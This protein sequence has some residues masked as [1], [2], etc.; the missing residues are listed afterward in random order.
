LS[1]KL[2]EKKR[3]EDAAREA[4]AR[5]GQ[6]GS[7]D[8]SEKIRTYNFPQD[9][10]TDHR[11]GHTVHNLARLMTGDIEPFLS[12]VRTKLQAEQLAAD[13]L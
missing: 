1:T 11:V 4:A 7:G 5:K 6:V 10:C 3:A 8:R 9:R 2:L 13:E 12:V